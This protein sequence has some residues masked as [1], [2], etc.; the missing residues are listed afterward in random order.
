[1][2]KYYTMSS[3][4]ASCTHKKKHGTKRKRRRDDYIKSSRP[5]APEYS[6]STISKAI[7]LV[8]GRP[9][10]PTM[11][12]YQDLPGTTHFNIFHRTG[13][14]NGNDV[15]GHVVDY[16]RNAIPNNHG[17]SPG[18]DESAHTEHDPDK[19][20][21]NMTDTPRSTEVFTV[22]EQSPVTAVDLRTRYD[23]IPPQTS[24]EQVLS[25]TT[26]ETTIGGDSENGSGNNVI[27]S[28][29]AGNND[30]ALR[31]QTF[32]N[33]VAL[34]LESS[35]SNTQSPVNPN[36][37]LI[38]MSQS[39][40]HVPQGRV[41]SDFNTQLTGAI[42]DAMGSPMPNVGPDAKN[43]D[44]KKKRL[45]PEDIKYLSGRSPAEKRGGVRNETPRRSNRPNKGVTVKRFP[46]PGNDSNQHLSR[47]R[48]GSGT[49]KN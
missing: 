18:S 46:S 44:K 14:P 2:S 30:E 35:A 3:C 32:D 48:K 29:N 42:N 39:M 25:P 28:G 31:S 10:L 34:A 6:T 15:L 37:S 1:M 20:Y 38:P 49:K 26:A 47:Y 24:R 21:A 36:T 13:V 5:F 45:T 40:A 23:E 33:P 27:L 17:V 19:I 22:G 7:N 4:T 8:Y 9:E 11:S 12:R 43:S 16:Q 41:S